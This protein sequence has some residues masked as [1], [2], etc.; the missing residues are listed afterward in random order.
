MKQ[1]TKC[2]QIKDESEF[3]KLHGEYIHQCKVCKVII[4]MRYYYKHQVEITR[5]SKERRKI[6][7]QELLI[8]EKGYRLCKRD[9]K[10]IEA[11]ATRLHGTVLRGARKDKRGGDPETLSTAYFI[12][13]LTN[14]PNCPCCGIKFDPSYRSDHLQ[15]EKCPSIDKFDPSKGYFKDNIVIICWRC[16]RLKC[17]ATATEL[18][19]IANWIDAYI[20][21]NSLKSF[22]NEEYIILNPTT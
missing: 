19:R 2:K 16:N 4:C 5:K 20:C 7:R 3:Y 12:E 18:R 11:R 6:M 8:R 9:L 22:R 10:P 17:D 15:N 13:L 21:D 14:Q 1:C